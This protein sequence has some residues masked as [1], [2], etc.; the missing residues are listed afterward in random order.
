MRERPY[1]FDQVKRIAAVKNGWSAETLGVVEEEY[2]RFLSEA[3]TAAC[4]TPVPS[5]D[6][7]LLWHEHLLHTATYRTDCLTWFGR[8]LDHQPCLSPELRAELG[9]RAVGPIADSLIEPKGDCGSPSPNPG[10][11]IRDCGAPNQPPKA[12]L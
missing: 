10:P 4:F 1:S 11:D 5:R 7:D 2:I 8:F 12:A 9:W 6:V 3:A